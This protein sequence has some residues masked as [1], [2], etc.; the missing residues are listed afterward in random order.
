M[1]VSTVFGAA[2][3]K[4]FRYCLY[5]SFAACVSAC[6]STVDINKVAWQLGYDSAV[7]KGHTFSHR[8]VFKE[9]SGDQLHVYIEGDGYAWL[10][11]TVAAIDPT[12][13][14]SLMLEMMKLDQHPALF[15]GRP[16]YFDTSDPACSVY[17]WTHGRYSKMVIES[18]A[19]V[20]IR[21][22][23]KYDSVVLIGHSGGGTIAMLLADRLNKLSTVITLAGNLDVAQWAS[24]HK[25]S[26]LTGSLNPMVLPL[27]DSGIKQKHYIGN[28]DRE[29]FPAWTQNYVNRYKDVKGCS[30]EFTLLPGV[31]HNRGWIDQ[32]ADLLQSI[33]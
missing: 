22:T 25:Y 19:T 16:C 13:A 28:A 14:G 21:E 17:Y 29:I 9:G 5:C 12:P 30:I 31:E 18:M 24:H 7:V 3:M 23:E 1:V 20:L 8:L 2:R 11:S 32:W 6:S 26:A 15:L 27:L 4:I 10:R 33:K